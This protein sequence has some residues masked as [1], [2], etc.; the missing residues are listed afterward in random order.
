MR[1]SK[2]ACWLVRRVSQSVYGHR[3]VAITYSR[4]HNLIC[5][6]TPCAACFFFKKTC[7]EAD[8]LFGLRSRERLSVAKCDGASNKQCAMD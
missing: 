8:S 3:H 4:R 5:A 7:V 6:A 2:P 1:A